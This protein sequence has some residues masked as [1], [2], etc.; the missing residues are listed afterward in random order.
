MPVHHPVGQ[1]AARPDPMPDAVGVGDTGMLPWPLLL[2]RRLARRVGIDRRWAIVMV[3]LGGLFTVS[4][5][6]TIL[7]VSLER[8]ATDLDSSVATVSWSLTGPM[9]AFGVVGPAFGKA[10]DMFGHKRVFV[11]GIFFAGVFAAATALA[12]DA[13]SMIG[14]RTLSAA[15]GSACGPSAM[16]YINRLFSPEERVRPL[17]YWSFVGAGAPVLGVVIGAPIVEAH[18]WRTIFWGQAPLCV[19][20]AVL[21][22][23]LL[24]DTERQSGVRFDVRGSLTL[25]VGALCVLAAIS[26]GRE[27]GWTSA[28][29]LSVLVVGVLSLAL[30][31][32]IERVV[33][34]PLVMMRWFRT[35]NVS[36][37]VLSQFLCNF[38]YMGSF[39]LVPQLMTRGLGMR[40]TEFS[41]L[42]IA[43]PIT[44]AVIAPIG[45]LLA[46][47]TG[48]RLVGVVG[49]LIVAASMLIWYLVDGA[50]QHLLI[51]VA[52]AVSGLG[53]G[54]TSPSMTS[55]TTNAVD[56]AD[57][58][59]AGAMQ[60]LAL[61]MG[62]VLGATVLTTMALSGGRGNLAPFHAAMWVGLAVALAGAAVATQVRS[63]PRHEAEPLSR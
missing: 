19:V 14:L 58:G 34:Q 5:T 2:R 61:Q 15:C 10:G 35:R 13:W 37:P 11:S 40:E 46:I 28:L 21:A 63:T 30:F 12:W 33:A 59:V 29:T 23:W 24:P 20:G 27:W 7:V 17:S 57:V 43:R 48:E 6:I 16:A 32:R 55:L 36:L 47:R 38:T 53:L 4:C 49:S 39:I 44:F 8:I 56:P 54:L 41:T 25:G 52:L 45:G 31:G 62:A 18:G 1:G 50:N 9:L 60:Q 26:Q 3:V 42:I 51:V 22:L